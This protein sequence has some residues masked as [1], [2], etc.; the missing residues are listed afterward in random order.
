MKLFLIHGLGM[1]PDRMARTRVFLNGPFLFRVCER[2]HLRPPLPTV[3]LP[4]T[5][6][7]EVF[8]H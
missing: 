8:A 6:I 3:E 2:L 1:Q 7:R 5:C 4:K